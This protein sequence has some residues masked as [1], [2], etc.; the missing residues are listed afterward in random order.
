[1]VND[2]ILHNTISKTL[3]ANKQLVKPGKLQ[4][5]DFNK[6]HIYDFTLLNKFN[7]KDD[8]LQKL[9]NDCMQVA[10]KI[11]P[12]TVITTTTDLANS[13]EYIIGNVWFKPIMVYNREGKLLYTIMK[14]VK[15]ELYHKYRKSLYNSFDIISTYQDQ[16]SINYQTEYKTTD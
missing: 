2:Y 3:K 12:F 13:F 11:N 8:F 10:N 1:M 7:I 4:E 9:K 16:I 15:C 5:C 14:L 6:K